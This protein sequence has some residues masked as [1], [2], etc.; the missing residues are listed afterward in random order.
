MLFSLTE[1]QLTPDPFITGPFRL[2]QMDLEG[3]LTPGSFPGPFRLSQT[4]LE[5]IDP[6]VVGNKLKLAR[7]PYKQDILLLDEKHHTAVALQ[8]LPIG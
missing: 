2:F 5:T 8:A 6:A 1:G 7:I 4:G 3:Q